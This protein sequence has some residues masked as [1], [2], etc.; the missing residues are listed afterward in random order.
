M[1]G[2]CREELLN[3]NHGVVRVLFGEKVAAFHRLTVRVRRPLPQ[4][5]Q[6]TAVFCIESV[7][8]ATFGPKMQHRTL[9][10]PGRFL[11]R[12]IM[13]DIDR[14]CGSIL[15]ADSVNAGRIAIGGNVLFENF[16]AE[17]AVSE[18]VI[19][20]SLGSAEQIAL[21][22]RGFL[23]QQNPGPVGLREARIGPAPRLENR[24]HIEY[25][26][27][28]YVFRMVQSQTVGDASSAVVT[29]ERERR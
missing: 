11:V 29:D 23:R 17:G 1:I 21:R 8:R 7:E 13:L 24:N 4:N 27:T 18:G 2:L 19:E 25:S 20:D 15:L 3:Q 12:T 26:E 9:D 16:W 5:A 22:K 10:S 14:G 6:R 28:L